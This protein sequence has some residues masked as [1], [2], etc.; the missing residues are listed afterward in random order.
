MPF[1]LDSESLVD[2]SQPS[3][4]AEHFERKSQKRIKAHPRLTV[5]RILFFTLTVGFGASKAVS[6][7]QGQTTVPT[8]FDWIY[9]IVVVSA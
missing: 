6:S 2:N 3:A 9:G 4:G 1:D 7:Y 8:T 5:Y